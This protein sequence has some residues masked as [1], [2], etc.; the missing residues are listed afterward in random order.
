MAFD[1]IKSIAEE[2]VG[3][4]LNLP[5]YREN[6]R[7]GFKEPSFFISKI[8]GH[9][10]PNLFGIQWRDNHY[11]VV[12]F[13]NADGANADMD[14][15]EDFLSDNFT[16]LQEFAKIRDL[17]FERSDSTLVATFKVK[18]RAVPVDQGTKQQSLDFE[19]G[20]KHD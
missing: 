16:Q 13:P 11:E 6:Q 2:L 20:L 4:G 12:Y 18:F 17:N 3:M 15:M 9:I 14:A 8:T 1:I 10:Q 7:G 5:I 19:G